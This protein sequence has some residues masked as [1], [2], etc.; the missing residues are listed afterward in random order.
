MKFNNTFSFSGHTYDSIG[1]VLS[2]CTV[3]I[4]VWTFWPNFGRI[5]TYSTTSNGTGFFNLTGIS[6]FQGGYGYKPVVTHTNVNG[7]ID[8][9]GKSLPEFPYQMLEGLPNFNFYLDEA[10]AINITA[11]NSTGSPVP[12]FYSIK[13][14]NL[15]FP[16]KEEWNTLT[17]NVIEYVSLERNYSVVI[18]PNMSFP[19]NE[20]I[21]NLSDY[22]NNHIDLQFNT[23]QNLVWVSGYVKT[24]NNSTNFTNLSIISYVTES[25][26]IVFSESAFPSNMSEWRGDG[27]SDVFNSTSG[28]YNITL[29]GNNN[30]MGV[31][32][33]VI[34][35]DSGGDG[36]NYIQY[37]NVTLTNTDVTNNITVRPAAG[38]FNKTITINDGLGGSINYTT[39]ATNFSLINST[40]HSI[41]TFAF[42]DFTIDYTDVDGAEFH[43]MEDVEASATG[44]FSLTLLADH[45]VDEIEVFTESAPTKTSLSV[46]EVNNGTTNPPIYI[47]VRDFEPGA[48]E[49]EIDDDD[50]QMRMYKSSQSCSVPKPD[51][52]LCSKGGDGQT[53]D[54]FDPMI[55]TLGGG[56]V[57]FAMKMLST[58]IE[59]RYIDV[60]LL[61]SGPPDALFDQAGDKSTSGSTIEEVWRFGSLGPDIY[62]WVLIGVPYDPSE[63][64]ENNDMT[65][66]IDYFYDEDWN[67]VWERGVNDL[68][69]VPDDYSRYTVD[70]YDDYID[71]TGVLCDPDDDDLS[72]GLC[73]KDTVNNMLWFKIPHFSGIGPSISGSRSSSSSGSAG[74]GGAG[75]GW[76]KI[77][78]AADCADGDD[79]DDDG[80]VDYPY[81]PGCEDYYDET[82][83]NC[84][85]E[86]EC[87]NWPLC[88][89]DGV[90]TREC[91]DL[92]DCSP[93]TQDPIL[94]KTCV[95]LPKEGEPVEEEEESGMQTI[96]GAAVTEAVE[97]ST[98]SI[99]KWY[100]K[101][102]LLAGLT[103]LIILLYAVFKGGGGKEVL[104]LFSS[105][106]GSYNS[107]TTKMMT[108]YIKKRARRK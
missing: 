46:D 31:M 77:R 41:S 40:N 11:V 2:G 53:A 44:V 70:P 39:L 94:S 78:T 7:T 87:T 9:I 15:G 23:S 36:I 106:E 57:D 97:E 27:S 65:M 47:T 25:G 29:I 103:V 68:A 1:N 50:I 69:S 80:Y 61:A 96:T 86:W 12:F 82:E 55:M 79:N 102:L 85:S 89:E 8:Y 67:A 37:S 93:S 10:G 59:V 74:S 17:T 75:G 92:N 104:D 45:D 95:Y 52:A 64:N 107:K 66:T 6:G 21:T 49:G 13:D 18:Y 108:S 72:S 91:E 54:R 81:D 83:E 62:K 22:P 34:A 63:F 24:Q 28:F 73:Y 76:T 14:I 90:V 48:I 42:V 84:W 19:I 99:F 35:L 20:E 88:T 56:K 51:G 3:S 98:G 58:G 38:S 16:V 26:N 4:E 32:M 5:K 105:K 30:G 101:A 60:D 43:W 33:F 71:G 100:A